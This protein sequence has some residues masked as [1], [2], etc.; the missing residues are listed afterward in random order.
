[1]VR[2]TVTLLQIYCGVSFA[3]TLKL[4]QHLAKL[5][6]KSKL[7]QLGSVPRGTVL[8]KDE[9]LEMWA[10]DQRDGRPAEHRWRPLFNAEKFADA[11][12]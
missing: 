2:L 9:K 7:P 12:Y 10:N 8:L 11:H 5:W 1:M 6:G 3:G 4:A